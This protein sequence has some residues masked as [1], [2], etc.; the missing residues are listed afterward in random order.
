[1]LYS[2]IKIKYH[3]FD[4]INIET[5]GSECMPDKIRD[6]KTIPT[7]YKSNAP[8]LYEVLHDTNFKVGVH[9]LEYYAICF[10]NAGELNVETNI[11][12]HHVKAPAMFVIAPD[13]IRDFDHSNKDLNMQVL[14]FR[15][16]YFLKGQIDINLLDKYE[17]LEQKDKHII[18]LTKPEATKF[19]RYFQFV[20]SKIKELTIN[21]PEIIRSFIYI[22]LN[23]MDEILQFKKINRDHVLSRNEQMLLDFKILASKHFI[24]QRKLAFYADKL[25]VTSKYLSTVI[26][27]TSGKTASEWIKELLLLESKVLL[28][29]N[30]LSI[31]EIASLLQFTDLSHF[32]KF[33][34][35][36]TNLSPLE[37][38]KNKV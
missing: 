3:T 20:E 37:F 17:F 7:Y 1:M 26:K 6:S 28:K 13:V 9:R 21:T 22:L 18:P 4:I 24:E 30:K 35:T 34:K 27:Q 19:A 2:S 8:F 36:H 10:L 38:R 16:E 33:F 25:N 14:M 23:E 15:K 12:Y 11:F 32:G 31:S 29:D 5:K